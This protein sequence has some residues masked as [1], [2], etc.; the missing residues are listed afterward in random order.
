[1]TFIHKYGDE[2]SESAVGESCRVRRPCVPDFS[3]HYPLATAFRRWYGGREA[4]G[5]S[6]LQPGFSMIGFIPE[7]VTEFM[8][9]STLK[10]ENGFAAATSAQVNLPQG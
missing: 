10:Q 5:P 2:P 4:H 1:M 6:R 3:R 7:Y 8:K 9:W